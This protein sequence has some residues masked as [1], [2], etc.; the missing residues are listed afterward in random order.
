VQHLVY[1]GLGSNIGDRRA[2]LRFALEMLNEAAGISVRRVS[3]FIETEPIGPPQARYLNGAARLDADQSPIELLHRLQLIEAALGRDHSVEEHW[4]PR[5][6][7][8]DILLIDDIVMDTP[9]LVIPHPRMHERSFVLRPL[10]E[11][12]AKAVHPVLHKTVEDLLADLE[13][14]P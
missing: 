13:R 14:R 4:G 11:I 7:D 9:E 2:H 8:L 6:C 1:I 3:R 10:A 5:T 12:A